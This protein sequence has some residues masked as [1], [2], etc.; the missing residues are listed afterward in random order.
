MKCCFI[1]TDVSYGGGRRYLEA[2]IESQVF[3]DI[4][5]LT[6]DPS[7]EEIRV[8]GNLGVPILKLSFFTALRNSRRVF[9]VNSQRTLL[10]LAFLIPFLRGAYYVTHGFSNGLE[11]QSFFRRV[12]YRLSMNIPRLRVIGCGLQEHELNKK[13]CLWNRC[14]LVR[15]GI[16]ASSFE[17]FPVRPRRARSLV[18]FGRISYQKGFD[19]LLRVA[20][21]TG[22]PIKAYGDWESEQM[23]QYCEGLIGS[24]GLDVDFCGYRHISEIEFRGDMLFVA[25][26]RFEGLPYAVLEMAALKIPVLLS[27]CNGHRELLLEGD[28]LVFN[29]ED[30]QS[31]VEIIQSLSPHMISAS[32]DARAKAALEYSFER[33]VGDLRR[34]F[35]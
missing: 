8:C 29:S 12:L 14:Y 19:I 11:H 16:N 10:S 22:L 34:C 30:P 15:N 1:I 17:A 33:F 7:I 32:V 9:L 21:L 3:S 20:E 13:M 28:K 2:V 31:C 24:K 26:S 27:D 6:N 23:R 25:P 18:F 35:R 4:L 5:V